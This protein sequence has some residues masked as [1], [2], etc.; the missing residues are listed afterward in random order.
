MGRRFTLAGLLLWTTFAGLVLAFVVPLWREATRQR[1]HWVV[2]LA[3]S[4]DGSTFAA[5]MADRRVLVWDN[6]GNLKKQ[7]KPPET[8]GGKLAL[9][10]DGKLIAFLPGEDDPFSTAPSGPVEIW[11]VDTGKRRRTLPRPI[12][13]VRFSPTQESFIVIDPGGVYAPCSVADESPPTLLAAGPASVAFSPD[14]KTIA[15]ASSNGVIELY[16]AV[17]SRLIQDKDLSSGSAAHSIHGDIAWA[18]D[19]RSILAMAIDVRVARPRPAKIR[20]SFV[21]ERWDIDTGDVRR[22]ALP[23]PELSF[24]L[25]IAYLPGNSQRLIVTNQSGIQVL[26]AET[27]ERLPTDTADYSQFAVGLR[28]ESLIAATYDHVDLLD[29]ATLE[30]RQ[31]LVEAPSPFNPAPVAIGFVV[32]LMAF[33]FHKGRQNTRACETC[34]QRFTVA[35]KKD[36]NVECPACRQKTQTQVLTPGEAATAERRQQRQGWRA[37]LMFDALLAAGFALLTRGQFGFWPAFAAAAVGLPAL[38]LG[39]LYLYLRHKIKRGRI[40]STTD[41]VALADEAAGGTGTVRQIGELFVWSA[42]GMSLAD[43]LEAEVEVIRG[44]LAAAIGRPVPAPAGRAFFFADSDALTRYFGRLDIRLDARF[45]HN[46]IY[47]GA[48]YF[49]LFFIEQRI[50][51]NSAGPRPAFGTTIFFHLLERADDRKHAAWLATGLA[52]TVSHDDQSDDDDLGRLHRRVLAGRAGGRTIGS[53]E[54]LTSTSAG[55]WRKHDRHAELEHFAWSNQFVAQAW[56]MVE[57]L[58][59]RGATP[60]RRQAFQRFFNDA[61]RDKRPAAAIERHFGCSFD[62]LFER[63][64]AWVAERG[65][66]EHRPPPANL[67]AYLTSDPI[68][69]VA[70]ADTPR[71]E[72]AAAI[73]ELGQYGYLLGAD[74]LV[75]LLERQDENL[76]AEAIWALECISGEVLGTSAAAWQEWWRRTEAAGADETVLRGRVQGSVFRV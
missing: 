63:W 1:S 21:V 44:R 68:A 12:H 30:S 24:F 2:S 20:P 55:N 42:P 40:L 50:R 11:S 31:R 32:W 64:Q 65:L 67:A 72:R 60:D 53:S 39:P 76:R 74:A 75:D 70:A 66:G 37:L 18:P 19:G 69:K 5:L 38:V 34:G 23:T 7:L 16:D 71:G 15:A 22:V 51:Q 26:D 35:G 14:G 33:G 57:F 54:F 10:F 46:G 41:D 62:E 28:G 4:A 47:L 25:A 3:A 52:A 61:D 56:S 9:S 45:L 17:A 6:E 27:L 58:C 49:K 13:E 73:R 8:V 43:E 29:A 48:P 59:G 36:T